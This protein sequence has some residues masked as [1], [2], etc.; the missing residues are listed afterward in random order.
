MPSELLFD[1]V[2]FL[3]QCSCQIWISSNTTFPT[4]LHLHSHLEFSIVKCWRPNDSPSSF[5]FE[6][7]KVFVKNPIFCFESFL[8][9]FNFLHSNRSLGPNQN[10]FAGPPAS[11]TRW[12]RLDNS[13]GK[14]SWGFLELQKIQ[15]K[16]P[17][18]RI[19]LYTHVYCL[20]TIAGNWRSKIN[21]NYF[22]CRR[23]FLA[24]SS[25]VWHFVRRFLNFPEFS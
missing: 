4:S 11:P 15:K 17:H 5:D 9:S 10:D 6:Q 7:T 25:I 20:A 1:L 16:N 24:Y 21:A 12:N 19:Y 8:F 22:L 3:Q 14:M 13:S 23:A 2:G 18:W